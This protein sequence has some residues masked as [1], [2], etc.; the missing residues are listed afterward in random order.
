MKPAGNLPRRSFLKLA[1]ASTVVTAGLAFHKSAHAAGKEEIRIGLIGA[2][3]RGGGA[4]VDCMGAD[5]A[6]RL[7]AMCDI[8]EDRLR[9]RKNFLLK[10]YPKQIDCPDE[11]CFSGFEGYKKVIELSDL[12]LIACASKFHPMYAE[13]AVKAGKH[14]FLEKPHAIDPPGVRRLERTARIAAEK[15]LCFLSGLQS[16]FSTPYREMVDRIRG[17]EIGDVISVQSMLLRGSSLLPKRPQGM[18]ETEFQLSRWGFFSWLSG[19][20]IPQAL[21]H[22]LDRAAWAMDEEIPLRAYALAGRSI[23]YASELFDHSSIVYEYSSGRKLYAMCRAM[24]NC[25][26]AMSDVVTGTKAVADITRF[27]IRKPNGDLIHRLTS[28]KNQPYHAEQEVLIK[29]IKTGEPINSGYHMINSSMLGVLGQLAAYQG[30]LI[31]YEEAKNTDFHL[32]NIPPDEVNFEIE[33]PV[34]PDENGIYPAPIPG[35]TRFFK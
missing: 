8:F 12:V 32:G 15:R 21:V 6:V 14:V 23:P 9:L 5:P 16:R 7:V 33:P 2:G 35:I 18:S 31:G 3:V 4:V 25:H 30:N 19:D 24:S 13:A 26:A 10:N 27:Q 17:G 20:D 11:N 22:N 28:P 34:K 1:A 29:A